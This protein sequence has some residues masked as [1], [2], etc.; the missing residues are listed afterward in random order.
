MGLPELPYGSVWLVGAGGGDPRH[1]SPLAVHA[2]GTADAVIHDPV[3]SQELLDLVKPP[4]YRETATPRRA[5][6]RAMKLAQD[7]WRV[8]YFVEGNTME[9]VIE[10]GISFAEQD[11]PFCIVPDAGE[12]IGGEALLG[13][14][15][16]RKAVSL[17]RAHAGS[18]LV[19]LAGTRET[20][21]ALL[22]EQR[23]PP[24]GFSMSGLA[25]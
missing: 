9:R 7:G 24:L 12:L 17:W 4:H 11:I 23:L 6:E 13:I 18:S 25:G 3:V 19:L 21:A 15:L 8:V 5:I 10:C 22:L 1:L 20:E 16:V 2:L 14:L